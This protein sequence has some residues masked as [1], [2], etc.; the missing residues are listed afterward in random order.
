MDLQVTSG[1]P[2]TGAD[3]APAAQPDAHDH[4]LATETDIDD[5][6]SGQAEHPVEC[7]LD[8][9][10]VLLCG[11]LS[12]S[13]Q[14]PVPRSAA[15]PSRS[16]QPPQESSAAKAPLTRPLPRAGHPQLDRRPETLED[17]GP[18]AFSAAFPRFMNIEGGQISVSTGPVVRP[19]TAARLPSSASARAPSTSPARPTCRCSRVPLRVVCR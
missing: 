2:A 10:V 12:F 18:H 15:R 16:A 9:H 1:L 5:R 8:A 4:P 17:R 14:Q 3:P 11:P 13:T 6:C 19:V 7:G